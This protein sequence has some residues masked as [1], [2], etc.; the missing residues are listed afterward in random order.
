M[1]SYARVYL[2]LIQEKTGM[3][4]E[5]DSPWWS[6][7]LRHAAW[8]VNRFSVRRDTRLTAFAKAHLKSYS[9]PVLPLGWA[10]WCWRDDLVP[11]SR[12]QGHG[13]SLDAGLDAMALRM[14]T[15]LARR[16]ASSGPVP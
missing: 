16:R 9:D 14:N 12:R 6:W 7:A 15:S 5:S 10:I 11:T 3:K 8:T 2:A 13:L 1:Q 4:A